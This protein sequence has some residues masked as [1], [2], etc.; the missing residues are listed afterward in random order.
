[1]QKRRIHKKLK[2]LDYKHPLMSKSCRSCPRCNK[3]LNPK[4][5][6]TKPHTKT[7]QYDENQPNKTRPPEQSVKFELESILNLSPSILSE[8][9]YDKSETDKMYIEEKSMKSEFEIE[10]VMF[11]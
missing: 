9:E 5:K 10:S 7:F 2:R 4:P 1:M 3:A 8:M 6:T 11:D